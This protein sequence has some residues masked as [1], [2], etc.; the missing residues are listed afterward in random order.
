[1]TELGGL[2]EHL[3]STA[4]A[5]EET[6]ARAA[7]AVGAAGKTVL[8]DEAR[9]RWGPDRRWSGAVRSRKRSNS[10]VASAR[11]DVADGGKRV[12]WKPTG[13]PWLVTIR[14]RRADSR[15]ITPRSPVRAFNTPHGPRASQ[16]RV[17]AMAPKGNIIGPLVPRIERDAVAALHAEWVRSLGRIYRAG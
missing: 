13:T 7:R 5:V 4:L 1:M 6:P 15:R 8:F 10:R 3:R 12:E 16:Q 11:Y 2:A 14:G 17:T 9:R